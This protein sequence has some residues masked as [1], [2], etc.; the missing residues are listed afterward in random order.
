MWWHSTT[1]VKDIEQAALEFNNRLQQQVSEELTK[2]QDEKKDYW[3]AGLSLTFPVLGSVLDVITKTATLMPKAALLGSLIAIVSFLALKRKPKGT[4][5]SSD[6]MALT[7]REKAYLYMNR[8]WE[9][10]RAK[11]AR[12]GVAE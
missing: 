10:R 1:T 2:A 6:K 9:I 7:S 11:I 12:L 4:K 5:R 3:Y 8:L